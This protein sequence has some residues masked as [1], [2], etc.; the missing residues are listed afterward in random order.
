MVI[1]TPES[2]LNVVLPPHGWII[3]ILSALVWFK[4]FVPPAARL[5]IFSR[6]HIIPPAS[7]RREVVLVADGVFHVIV[8]AGRSLEMIFMLTEG[9]LYVVLAAAME[10]L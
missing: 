4:L 7:M 1:I 3:V 8:V 9:R 5:E 2:S 10:R 6:S